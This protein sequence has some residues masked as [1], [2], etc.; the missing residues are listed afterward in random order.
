MVIMRKL[1]IDTKPGNSQLEDTRPDNPVLLDAK[2]G[3]LKMNDPMQLYTRTLGAG[4]Y[5]GI[6]IL[7]Y[8]VAITGVIS[9]KS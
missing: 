4:M 2:P 6:P 3:N 8:P 7:T 1:L 9:G 5:L